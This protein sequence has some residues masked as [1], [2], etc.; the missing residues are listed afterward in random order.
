M[1]E[2]LRRVC[3]RTINIKSVCIESFNASPHE[4]I[5]F[6]YIKKIPN[7]WIVKPSVWHP[8]RRIKFYLKI[9]RQPDVRFLTLAR[10]FLNRHRARFLEKN[11]ESSLVTSQLGLGK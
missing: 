9:F 5:S 4:L 7:F 8:K 10:E 1:V 3:W 2:T 11:P 6:V